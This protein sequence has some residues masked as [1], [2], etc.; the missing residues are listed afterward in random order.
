MSVV[1]TTPVQTYKDRRAGLVV[2]GI[3]QIALGLLAALMSLLLVVGG[4]AGNAAAPGAAPPR[5][6]APVALLYFAVAVMFV[7]LGIGSIRA[8]RWARAIILALSW[9]WLILGVMTCIGFVAM[10]P[11][12]FDALPQE[13]ASMKPMI[14]GCM[15]VFL[16]LFFVVLPLV[17]VLFYRGPNVRA[18]VDAVD[19]VPRWTDGQPLPLLIFAFWTLSGGLCMLFFGPMYTAFPVGPWMLRGVSAL[20][21]MLVI[22]GVTLFIGLGSLKRMRAAWWTALVQLVVG[23]LYGAAFMRKINVSAWYKAMSMPIDPRQLEMIQ[24]TLSS[25]FFYLWM[26]AVWAVYLGL[27][28]YLR[29]Y[30]FVRPAD[31]SAH[32]A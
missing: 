1:P 26:A 4:L 5:V 14:I 9:M 20:A 3:L 29:R 32:W 15:S 27:L 13:Q 25:P 2:F 19:A 31:S 24:S 12:M 17:F 28:L 6:M 30:F 18:T 7:V 16:G 21:L 10:S 8:R 23:V 11:H 22:A